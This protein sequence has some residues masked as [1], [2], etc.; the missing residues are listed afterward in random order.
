MVG[1]DVKPG[2][3]ENEI[4]ARRYTNGVQSVDRFHCWPTCQ[5]CR[6]RGE[7]ESLERVQGFYLLVQVG[8]CV[9]A[10]FMMWLLIF[11]VVHYIQ[12]QL[13]RNWD[14]T[15]MRIEVKCY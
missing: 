7:V 1:S 14:K 10:Y 13:F 11:E 3:I 8:M 15:G 4:E 5:T 12:L 9:P 6:Q 2:W